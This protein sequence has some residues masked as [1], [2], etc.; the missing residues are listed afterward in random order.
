MLELIA[1]HL[2]SAFLLRE[3]RK[4]LLIAEV[5]PWVNKQFESVFS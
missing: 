2:A 5:K 1:K 4:V 3:T